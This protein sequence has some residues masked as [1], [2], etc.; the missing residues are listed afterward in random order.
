MSQAF[1]HQ[2]R[3]EMVVVGNVGGA[4]ALAAIFWGWSGFFYAL[5]VGAMI[6]SSCWALGLTKLSQRFIE[7]R[8]NVHRHVVVAP[9]SA[10]RSAGGTHESKADES[11][12]QDSVPNPSGTGPDDGEGVDAGDGTK[13]VKS[14]TSCER[15]KGGC[16]DGSC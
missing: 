3:V 4:I 1:D 13:Y 5:V 2:T 8:S 6:L 12:H 9:G 15:G 14:M 10:G 11:S 16:C 7:R